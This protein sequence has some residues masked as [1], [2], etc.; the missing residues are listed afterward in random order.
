MGTARSWPT[1]KSNA[2]LTAKYQQ[3]KSSACS[4]QL[5]L[6]YFEFVF[7]TLSS[8]CDKA[9]AYNCIGRVYCLHS[10]CVS[11]RYTARLFPFWESSGTPVVARDSCYALFEILRMAVTLWGPYSYFHFG[12]PSSPQSSFLS[13]IPT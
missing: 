10:V 5:S 4:C 7:V 11:Q 8:I 13:G 1:P 12:N 6:M 9:I 3:S 2:L